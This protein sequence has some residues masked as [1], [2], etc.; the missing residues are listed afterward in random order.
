MPDFSQIQLPPD[1]VKMRHVGEGVRYVRDGDT[2][3]KPAAGEIPLQG[4]AMYF[5]YQTN[6]LW[7]WNRS[8]KT[9]KSVQLT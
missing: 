8:S 5:D 4:A 6:M 1:T 9:W 3:G 2:A 7:I